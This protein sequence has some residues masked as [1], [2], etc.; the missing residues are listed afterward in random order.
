M[1]HV[2]LSVEGMSCSHCVGRVTEALRKLE[3]V[4]GVSVSLEE[5]TARFEAQDDF[6]VETATAAVKEAGYAA[7][8]VV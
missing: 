2:T 8:P 4:E 6:A 7:A 1:K 5:K 3:G